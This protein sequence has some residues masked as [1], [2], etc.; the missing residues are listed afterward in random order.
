MLRNT[1]QRAAIRAAFES[2]GRPLSPE[3]VL[4]GAQHAVRGLGIATVYR[5]IK[6]LVEEGWLVSVALPGQSARYELSGKDHHHHFH[7]R[8]CGQVFELEGCV[9]GLRQM[10]PKGFQIAGHEVLLYGRCEPCVRKAR[11]S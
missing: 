6:A 2:A 7:C 4:S 11:N 10:V 1:R 5:N 8:D 9:E 3:E